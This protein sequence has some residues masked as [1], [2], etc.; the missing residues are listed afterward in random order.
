MNY[1]SHLL[2][3][4]LTKPTNQHGP[5]Q[6]FRSSGKAHADPQSLLHGAFPGAE[7]ISVALAC[8]GRFSK[9]PIIRFS[10]RTVLPQASPAQT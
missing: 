7:A 3:L 4:L 1:T 8:C 10:S 9:R 6:S 5:A 2:S